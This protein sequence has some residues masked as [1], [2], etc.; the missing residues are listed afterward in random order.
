MSDRP[1]VMSRRELNRATLAR[2]LLLEREPLTLV[3]AVHR[4]GAVQAQEPASP[5]LALWN[6]VV[7]FEAAALDRAF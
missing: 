2:Q 7:G 1:V 5:Y 6:R 3:E 4:I